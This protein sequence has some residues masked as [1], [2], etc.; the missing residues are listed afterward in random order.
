MKKVITLLLVITILFN[1][2]FCNNFVYADEDKAKSKQE[3]VYT[4]DEAKISNTAPEDIIQNGIVSTEQ[5]SSNKKSL[6]F[7]SIG[8]SA[9][10]FV[11]GILAR[12]VNILALLFDVIISS[13]TITGEKIDGNEKSPFWLTIDRIV[14]NRVSLFNINYFDTGVEYDIGDKTVITSNESNNKIKE[15]IRPVYYIC[16]ILAIVISLMVL[17][18]IGIRMALSTVASDQAKYKKMFLSWLESILLIFLMPYIMTALIGVGNVLTSVFYTIRNSLVG[19]GNVFE[20]TVRLQLLKNTLSFFGLKLTM[21]SMVYWCLLFME[22]KFLFL[23]AKRFLMVGLLIIVSPL[24]TITYPIDKI[25]DGK[26][27]AFSNWMQEFL[28]NVFIQP[29]HALIYLVFVLTANTI[30]IRAP[31]VAVALLLSMG[32]VEKM[33]KVVFN[34][35]ITTLKGVDGFMKKGK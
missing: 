7:N 35:N 2:I 30:A 19:D 29:L 26:A 27:Q 11:T 22:A 24:I 17:I 16:R 25:G 32:T 6:E 33:V 18:Y 12:I 31:L 1:F 8:V 10:G 23:Y 9:V 13:I 3:Q 28:I 5:D 4:K 14:F 21:W 15:S 20:D 34:M